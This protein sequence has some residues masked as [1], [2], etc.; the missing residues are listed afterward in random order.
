ME[1]T[2]SSMRYSGGFQPFNLSRI[3]HFSLRSA[4]HCS[5]FVHLFVTSFSAPV[6]RRL[7]AP[8]LRYSSI[9][10][11]AITALINGTAS[12]ARNAVHGR[13]V[14]RVLSVAVSIG[15]TI[16]RNRPR[17]PRTIKIHFNRDR[18]AS[19]W[20]FNA[21]HACPADAHIISGITSEH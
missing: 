1:P 12:M 10:I 20:Q 11:V 19:H 6:P 2:R 4:R 21:F 8:F 7:R 17:P 3:V 18:R 16:S 15:F 9:C 5:R 14:K 13:S